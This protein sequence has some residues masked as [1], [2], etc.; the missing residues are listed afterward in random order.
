MFAKMRR[1][2]SRPDLTRRLLDLNYKQNDVVWWL[3]VVKD[4]VP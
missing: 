2:I 4:Q 1:R 3:W